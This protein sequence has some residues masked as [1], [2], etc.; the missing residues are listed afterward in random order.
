MTEYIPSM[1]IQGQFRGEI[2]LENESDQ[3]KWVL[4]NARNLTQENSKAQLLVHGQDKS[5]SL[6]EQQK[7]ARLEKRQLVLAG[8]AKRFVLRYSTSSGVKIFKMVE[9]QSPGNHLIGVLGSSTAK[10]EHQYHLRCQSLGL[11]ATRSLGYLELR[12]GPFLIRACQIQE[13]ID[14]EQMLLLE[15]FF[16]QQL[17]HFKEEAIAAL[18]TAIAQMHLK[19]FFHGDLKGFHGFV[20][21]SGAYPSGAAQYDLLWIDLAKVGFNLSRRQRI[22]NLYQVF[23]YILPMN[24]QAQASFMKVY[25]DVAN[26]HNHQPQIA[27]NKV[28]KFLNYKLRTHPNP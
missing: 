15:T 23:R 21:T 26:W 1:N 20:R 18:A 7:Q 2:V 11:A 17:S 27:L 9:P 5:D 22:I 28:T 25:C 13:P 6:S 19:R 16:P 4:R 24:S 10:L 3:W 8:K 12:R 14:F